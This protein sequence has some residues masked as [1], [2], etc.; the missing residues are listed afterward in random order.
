MSLYKSYA[1]NPDSEIQGVEFEYSGAAKLLI[2][3][4]GGA[5]KKFQKIVERICKPHR[6]A[7]DTG[8]I[9]ADV[10]RRLIMEATVDAC[11][12]NW[13]SKVVD[14]E[15]GEESWEEGIEQ[16]GSEELLPVTK[17]NMTALFNRLP[18]FFDDVSAD[19]GSYASFQDE[20]RD[21]DGKN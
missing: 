12:L 8:R 16:V 21:S 7:L 4:S 11:I 14:T 5:N 18:D 9:K 6:R 13:W 19:S 17:D 2:A 20:G 10:L 1:T 15:T 3:R